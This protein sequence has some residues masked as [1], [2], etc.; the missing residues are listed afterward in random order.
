MSKSNYLFSLVLIYTIFSCSREY[1]L[2]SEPAYNKGDTL[3]YISFN[4]S[5]KDQSKWNNTIVVNGKPDYA[6]GINDQPG[7]AGFF[8]HGS[9][10]QCE[11][12]V[13]DSMRICFWFSPFRLSADAAILDCLDNLFSVYISDVNTEYIDA[14]SAATY[15]LSVGSRNGND[16]EIDLQAKPYPLDTSFFDEHTVWHHVQLISGAN[17][18]PVLFLNSQQVGEARPGVNPF[19][20]TDRISV[21]IGAEKS[22]E[23]YFC[24][25][26]DEF[27]I[28]KL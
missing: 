16:A 1:Q 6:I 9:S 18:Q 2:E 22:G 23:K 21:T 13:P 14:Y 5:F 27:I 28:Q 4:Q 11:F 8:N 15:T 3:I 19:A 17:S 12:D 7:N 10:L 24:G 26:I 20:N 25:K